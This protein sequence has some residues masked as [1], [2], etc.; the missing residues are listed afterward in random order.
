MYTKTGV[1]KSIDH[2]IIIYNFCVIFALSIHQ[3]FNHHLLFEYARK[4]TY[5]H[6]HTLWCFSIVD[7]AHEIKDRP[8]SV[9]KI[10]CAIDLAH[11]YRNGA[12]SRA[13]YTHKKKRTECA[14]IEEFEILFVLP[15]VES[16]YRRCG[17]KS[18]NCY[19]E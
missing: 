12:H 3:K 2:Y 14:T 18:R 6:T 19:G 17:A 10:K 13:S 1:V 15:C 4:R 8:F 16:A 7:D 11:N 9:Y 5:T